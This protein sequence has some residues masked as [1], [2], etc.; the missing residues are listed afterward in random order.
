MFLQGKTRSVDYRLTV[1]IRV[2]IDLRAFYTCLPLSLLSVWL[3]NP[4]VSRSTPYNQ[5][6]SAVN[7]VTQMGGCFTL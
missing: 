6:I 1:Y 4:V 5:W 2:G 3:F 7:T